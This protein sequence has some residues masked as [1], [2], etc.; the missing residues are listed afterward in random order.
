MSTTLTLH[1]TS[2]FLQ[3]ITGSS[4][5]TG[6]PAPQTEPWPSLGN[7]QPPADATVSPLL[8][9]ATTNFTPLITPGLVSAYT[10]KIIAGD[11]AEVGFVNTAAVQP[12]DM[13][14][15]ATADLDGQW[16]TTTT[17]Q[18]GNGSYTATMTELL[19]D[20]VTPFGPASA[21]L[22]INVNIP[23]LSLKQTADGS[24][25]EFAPHAAL[26]SGGGNWLHFDPLP[27]D[28]HLPAGVD[29]LLY[30]TMPD[31]T[32]VDPRWSYRHRRD[33][34]RRYARADGIDT[35]R[36]RR[37]SAADA[38]NFFS[39][40]RRATALRHP[41]QGRHDQRRTRGPHSPDGR[42]AG[43]HRRWTG[44]FR[45]GQQQRQRPDI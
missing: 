5:G 9:G 37:R 21:L 11:V 28:S 17:V 27:A 32:L 45:H 2:A 3:E 4:T 38:S 34:R 29:L 13:V 24:G 20:G 19:S 6:G 23:T 18:L 33:D 7:N 41:Q 44:I 22:T 39:A 1:L 31:G 35:E 12:L 25:L 40:G 26:G 36:W 8:P 15:H 42:L 43:G 10:N 14:L 30:A 16:Q